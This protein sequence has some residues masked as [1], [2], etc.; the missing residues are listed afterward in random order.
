MHSA[1]TDSFSTALSIPRADVRGEIPIS[2]AAKFHASIREVSEAR[3]GPV[4][5][6][7]SRQIRIMVD[8]CAIH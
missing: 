7:A 8:R 1:L 4:M 6:T 5:V 2:L 3:T